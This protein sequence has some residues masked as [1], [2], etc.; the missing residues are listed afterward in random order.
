M[1][2]VPKN[3]II[4]YLNINFIRNKISSFQGTALSKNDMILRSKTKI[5]YL[6]PTPLLF[7]EVFK[8]CRKYRTKQ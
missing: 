3:L 5:E 1:A 8:M 4:R 7:I 2:N 6:S